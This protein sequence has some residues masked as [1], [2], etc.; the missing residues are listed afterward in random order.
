M[1]TNGQIVDSG[2]FSVYFSPNMSFLEYN[3][4]KTF[5]SKQCG[6]FNDEKDLS[7]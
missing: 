7:S 3:I 5:C 6:V 1:I 2:M 4:L